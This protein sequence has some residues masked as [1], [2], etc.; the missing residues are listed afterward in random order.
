MV[1]WKTMLPFCLLPCFANWWCTCC[2]V[3]WFAWIR[4]G[5]S[6]SAANNHL[7]RRKWEQ[8]FFTRDHQTAGGQWD[9]WICDCFHPNRSKLF[10]VVTH[11]KLIICQLLIDHVKNSNDIKNNPCTVSRELVSLPGYVKYVD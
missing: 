9:T 5:Q 11:K 1:V 2:R 8:S 4:F 10:P 3:L 6:L 7:H